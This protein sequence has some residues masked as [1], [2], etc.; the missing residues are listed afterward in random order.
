[1]F[2]VAG[3]LVV[4]ELSE[5]IWVHEDGITVGAQRLGCA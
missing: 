1:M 3:R 5:D 2:Q 4:E